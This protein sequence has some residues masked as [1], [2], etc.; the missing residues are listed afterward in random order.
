MPDAR[1]VRLTWPS[2][3]ELSGEADVPLDAYPVAI[4]V[5][6]SWAYGHVRLELE[7]EGGTWVAA[8]APYDRVYLPPGLGTAGRQIALTSEATRHLAI[9]SRLS[10]RLRARAW[11]SRAAGA[12]I[13]VLYYKERRPE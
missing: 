12:Y 8:D 11:P 6:P 3:G 13:E 4:R 1:V 5:P 9:T 2:A 10:R 7:A